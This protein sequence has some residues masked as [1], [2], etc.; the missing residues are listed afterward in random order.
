[1][2]APDPTD[3]HEGATPEEHADLLTDLFTAVVTDCRRLALRPREI[4]VGSALALLL[5]RVYL[6]S[7]DVAGVDALAGAYGLPVDDGRSDKLYL[8]CGSV[9]LDGHEV[10][11]TVFTSRP[12]GL[13]GERALAV[14]EPPTRD[15]AAIAAPVHVESQRAQARPALAVAR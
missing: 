3:V 13:A 8:R 10:T 5:A 12:D 15:V 14:A 11:V 7:A 2:T 6:P 4:T 1:M 9:V